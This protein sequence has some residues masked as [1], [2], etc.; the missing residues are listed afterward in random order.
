MTSEQ[1]NVSYSLLIGGVKVYFPMKAY[2]SQIS[3]MDKVS[4]NKITI[5]RRNVKKR[6]V[7][8]LL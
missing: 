1:E 6:N 4:F 7:K 3:M 2:P 5:D 8:M